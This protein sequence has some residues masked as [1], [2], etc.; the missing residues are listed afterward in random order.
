LP[1]N[2]AVRIVREVL[3]RLPAALDKEAAALEERHKGVPEAA[4]RFMGVEAKL[5]RAMQKMVVPDMLKRLT[6]SE[7]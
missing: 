5:V 4:R 6:L 1:Y 2:V 7:T 3:S